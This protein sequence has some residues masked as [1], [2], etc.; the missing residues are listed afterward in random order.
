MSFSM[1]ATQKDLKYNLHF[2]R[3]FP[4]KE[5]QPNKIVTLQVRILN[6]IIAY[7]SCGRHGKKAFLPVPASMTLETAL[8]L[9]L[10]LFAAV[11]LILPMKIMT[12][13]RRIQAGL[14]SVGEDFS[15]YAYIQ[16]ALEDGKYISVPGAD[17]FAKGFCRNLGAGVA[18]GYA[19]A[20]A[21]GHADTGNVIS[22]NMLRSS[23]RE[24]GETFDLVMDYEIRM[25]FPVLGL[26]SISRT[27]RSCRRAWIGKAGKDEGDDGNGNGEED[28]IVYVGKDSTRYHRDRSCHYLSNSLTSV[29]YEA[30]GERRNESGKKYHAC[31]VCG[32]SAGVGSVVYIM[33][34][35]TSFHTTK[36]CTAII[37]Y[38]RAVHLSEVS[39][40]GPCSYCSR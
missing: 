34:S 3:K 9:S 14:E 6:R 37:A 26:S 12:T 39:Y 11:S 33:P 8:A 10:F 1:T 18:E 35:G 36:N 31:S 29:S 24:D 38:V 20:R 15:R 21:K 40:L 28:E 2:G 19:L 13:E 27:A 23:I 22:A 32:G 30:V 25:P 7:S 16:D 4:F 17:D 5:P